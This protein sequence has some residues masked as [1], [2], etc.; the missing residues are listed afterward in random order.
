MIKFPLVFSP[1]G[2]RVIP[3][4]K[5]SY[6]LRS[7]PEGKSP[8]LDCL[9]PIYWVTRQISIM[10]RAPWAILRPAVTVTTINWGVLNIRLH[11]GYFISTNTH[12]NNLWVTAMII[13]PILSTR[14]QRQLKVERRRSVAV[15]GAQISPH[16][17]LF[18]KS[19]IQECTIEKGEIV[20]AVVSLS[21][22]ICG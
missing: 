22:E 21:M 2:A 4:V 6:V 20:V 1:L 12:P 3:R 15:L 13:T 7:E 11:S 17:D 19:L 16:S 9:G 18:K 10:S 14:K 8:P 5:V